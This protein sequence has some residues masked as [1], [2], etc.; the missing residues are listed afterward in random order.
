MLLPSAR[1]CS[2]PGR[3]VGGKPSCYTGRPSLAN[4]KGQMSAPGQVQGMHGPHLALEAPGLQHLFVPSTP[5]WEGR[6]VVR[7]SSLRCRGPASLSPGRPQCLAAWRCGGAPSQTR[8][9]RS[10]VT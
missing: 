2:R 7:T 4:A 9:S 3:G 5:Q 1:L 10:A 8:S 6:A